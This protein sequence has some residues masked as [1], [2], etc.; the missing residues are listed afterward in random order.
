MC[1]H[2][3]MSGDVYTAP[4]QE[5]GVKGWDDE[6]AAILISVNY[7]HIYTLSIFIQ[8]ILTTK[9]TYM[10]EL[11]NSEVKVCWA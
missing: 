3:I 5:S 9:Y 6:M 1:I 11:C 2:V 4:S 7:A 8:K 10:Y